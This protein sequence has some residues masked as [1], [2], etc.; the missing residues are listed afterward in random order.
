MKR[1]ERPQHT[2]RVFAA[3]LDGVFC[4]HTTS[5]RQFDRH[6][7][8]SYGF[9]VM[10]LGGH[11]SASGRGR[12]RA[13]AG[14]AITT[15]PGEVHDGWPIDGGPRTWWL[16]HVEPAALARI[17]GVSADRLEIT[18][19]VIRDARL[20]RAMR[21]LFRR[22]GADD[23]SW[24]EAFVEACGELL[25]QHA[26]ATVAQHAPHD[27]FTAVRDRLADELVNPPSLAELARAAGLSRYQ[28]LRG[29][30]RTFGL[31]PHAWLRQERVERAK[32][33]IRRGV[34][35]ADAAAASGFADQSHMT[36]A[37]SRH[38]GFTPGVWQRCN[39]V[40]DRR[41]PV[42]Y[43]RGVWSMSALTSTAITTGKAN[44]S[45]RRRGPSTT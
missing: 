18:R 41:I 38:Y 39:S 40:Q 17:A 36:R 22:V 43:V 11:H 10:E 5:A 23:L 6:W 35:L 32:H 12:V 24:E 31:P 33:L 21:R 26:T 37:F 2:A 9:G 29:F 1:I 19:P 42:P 8:D 28:V 16:V 34:P 44:A 30:Q 25:S 7:H 13:Y 45:R 20:V 4:T 14:E 27:V 15:N 3:P